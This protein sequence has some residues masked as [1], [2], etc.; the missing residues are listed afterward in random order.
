MVVH[1]FLMISESE[2]RLE[3][4]DGGW[5][6]V[7]SAVSRFGLVNEYLAYLAARNYSPK[8]VRAYGYDLLAF[9]RWLVAE[10]QP[11]S[12]VTT[13]V[14]LRFMRVCRE[15]K[16]P[17]RPGPNVVRLSGRRMDRYAAT[18][19]N[20]R[21]AAVSGLFAFAA[22]RD[23]GVNNP[24]PKGR[25]SVWRVPGE[26]GGMLAHTVRRPKHRSSLRLREPRRLPT[27]LPQS[28][29]AQLLASFHTWRDRAIAGLMLYC[30]LRVRRR[31]WPWMSRTLIST[32]DGCGYWGRERGNAVSRSMPTW[33]R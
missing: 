18:T 28:E 12:G 32:V 7:G 27:A 21:L 11:L 15:A 33:P 26:R 1:L 20:R 2:L 25:Q 6:L 19:I 10:Q 8:T 3:E 9:C 5:T 29:A 17:G 16:I 24:V 22:M 23:P 13:E 14:L 4:Q 31:C 30:G